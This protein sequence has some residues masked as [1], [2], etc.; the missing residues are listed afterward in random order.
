MKFKLEDLIVQAKFQGG[1]H[2]LDILLEAI[3][4][5]KSVSDV[6]YCIAEVGLRLFEEERKYTISNELP[7]I[8]FDNIEV[9]VPED[10]ISLTIEEVKKE[11]EEHSDDKIVSQIKQELINFINSLSEEDLED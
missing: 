11:Y 8:N 9:D 3:S 1:V 2:V 6:Q 5:C 7:V 4:D 10:S